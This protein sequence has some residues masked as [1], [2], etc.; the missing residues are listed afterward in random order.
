MVIIYQIM[1]IRSRIL[2]Y[3]SALSMAVLAIAF[4][5]IYTLFY[6][7][8]QEDYQQRLKDHSIFT[9]TSLDEFEE[10]N[11]NILEAL[12]E[13]SV[14]RLYKE[15]TL[16]FNQQKK[17]IYSSVDDTV[18]E[19]P[20]ELLNELNDQNSLIERKEGEFDIIA[21]R[22]VFNKKV[23][24]AITKAQD[25]FGY[26]K[27]RY[28]KITLI[29]L[30]FVISG[31]I[32]LISF[33]LAKQ[34]SEPLVQMA[35]ALKIINIETANLK[36]P[37]P[38]IKDEIYLL[39]E[40]FNELL[41]SLQTA[42]AFQKNAIHHISHELK[43]P[44]A[45]L[46]SNLEMLEMETNKIQL[47]Q[48]LSFIKE[49]SKKLG[50]MVNILLDIAKVESQ[51]NLSFSTIRLDEIIFE[52][53]ENTKKIEPTFHFHIEIESHIESDEQVS[54]QGNQRLIAMAVQNL[55]NN[56]LLYAERKEATIRLKNQLN[57]IYIQVENPGEAI[58]QK[59]QHQLF[60]E[61]FRGQ[62]A[63]GK[64][65]LGLGLALVKKIL[66]LHKAEIHYEFFKGINR[67]EIKF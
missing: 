61:F 34:I 58:S 26:S 12:N 2:L 42:Y 20:N 13:V 35:T 63:Q 40:R 59:E 21:I 41:K 24:Y 43:T 3:F 29:I 32:L 5:L 36:L 16:I 62:H 52:C 28:L 55:L 15:K 7:Y 37:T 9:I 64:R 57:H 46:V 44:I 22:Y 31:I 17:L 30:F 53:I 14:N 67:F 6:N 4:F 10:L 19:F 27:L 54:I 18:I 23:F 65:G 50:D 48:G 33:L 38:D 49:D 66:D 45:V 51:A 56:C 8:R 25:I 47:K 39:S 60:T 1:N 11:Q